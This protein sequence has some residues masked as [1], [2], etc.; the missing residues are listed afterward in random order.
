MTNHYPYRPQMPVSAKYYTR[1]YERILNILRALD[2]NRFSLE[3]IMYLINIHLGVPKS[4]LLW[5]DPGMIDRVIFE[6]LRAD[7]DAAIARSARAR[8]AAARRRA[9]KQAQAALAA[10]PSASSSESSA[11]SEKSEMSASSAPSGKKN[12][13]SEGLTVLQSGD[14]NVLLSLLAGVA[15]HAQSKSRAA[16]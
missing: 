15:A 13:R 1:L 12:L 16:D 11:R 4:E 5:Q 3:R 8:A 10:Q 7:I 9:L 6:T 2:R 14:G